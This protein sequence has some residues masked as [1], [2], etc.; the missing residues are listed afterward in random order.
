MSKDCMSLDGE[1][2]GALGSTGLGAAALS[3]DPIF[4]FP[5]NRGR[6]HP[7]ARRCI[8]PARSLEQGSGQMPSTAQF[9]QVC[10]KGIS[11]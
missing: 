11:V 2:S 4:L 1:S 5:L 6:P 8:H 3:N 9:P 7:P 10:V